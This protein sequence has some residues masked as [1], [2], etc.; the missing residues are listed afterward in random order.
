MST[1]TMDRGADIGGAGEK[2]TGEWYTYQ[3]FKTVGGEKVPS[4]KIVQRV[5]NPDGTYGNVEYDYVTGILDGINVRLNK[6]APD[7]NVDPYEEI[8]LCLRGRRNGEDFKIFLP[9][10]ASSTAGFGVCRRLPNLDKGDVVEISAFVMD[11]QPNISIKRIEGG[12][13]VKVEPVE[14]GISF[15]S[16]ENLMGAKKTVAQNENAVMRE[17]W[18]LKT[19]R[20]LPYF[21]E[22]SGGA[23]PFDQVEERVASEFVL[24]CKLVA[25]KGWPLYG[26]VP[27]PYLDMAEKLGGAKYGSEAD[28]P[29]AVWTKM[30]EGA[31]KAKD[32]PKAV[33]E[34]KKALD[35]YDP[36]AEE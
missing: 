6:G 31:T 8:I 20:S 36:F 29:D 25:E 17:D 7:K 16:T 35:D 3:A 34:A 22:R 19:A 32:V 27:R 18:V 4:G 12:N 21:E 28:V 24:F 2:K 9:L 33:A 5:K 10:R 26:E 1:D 11:H 13:R 15:N 23:E 30:R 14:T